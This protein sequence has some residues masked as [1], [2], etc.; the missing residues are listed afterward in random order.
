MNIRKL[1]FV[2]LTAVL[3]FAQASRPS[4]D[5]P[6][7]IPVFDVNAIDKSVDPCVDF[8]QYAC[9]GWMTANPLPGDASRWGRFDSLQDRN[10]LLLNNVLETAAA[11]RPN[12]SALDQK[13]GD[14][15]AA[16]MDEKNIDARGLEAIQRD[17]NRIAVVQDRKE[18]A[19]LVVYMFRIG[20]WPFFRF[21]SEQDAKDS[22]RVIAVMDQAGLGLPD[23]DY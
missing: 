16:C 8:Y 3:S 2:L 11:D 13:I 15:Y 22:S 10:R 17:L 6:K 4:S 7:E 19:D 14:F 12:R 9:G 21:G 23:R 20:S 1:G 18:L 5:T